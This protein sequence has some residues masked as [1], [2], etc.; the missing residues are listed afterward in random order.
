VNN[1]VDM[2]RLLPR[3]IKN[4]KTNHL[5]QVGEATPFCKLADVI[6]ADQTVNRRITFASN[7]LNGIDGI[8]RRRT[9]QFA[10]IHSKSGFVFNSGLYHQQP[11]F[12]SG[13]GR[14]LS[15][16]R[17]ASWNKNHL[18]GAEFLKSL[19]CNDKM[20]VMNR[21]KCTSVDCDLFQRSTLNVQRSTFNQYPVVLRFIALLR[22]TALNTAHWTL[23]LSAW[24]AVR[25]PK[26]D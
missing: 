17:H 10:I 24:R 22:M 16:G 13:N 3:A 8:R 11:Y 5:F 21:I 15:E 25:L 7:L 4:N 14:G 9:P 18:I 19:T 6:L 1:R 23:K 20:A 12:V 26:V 2:A